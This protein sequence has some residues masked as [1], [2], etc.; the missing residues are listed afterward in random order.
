MFL[1]HC[2]VLCVKNLQNF[3]S[4]SPYDAFGQILS[5]D[6]ASCTQFFLILEDVHEEFSPTPDC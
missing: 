4:I 6:I 1:A 3:K 5:V 2:K